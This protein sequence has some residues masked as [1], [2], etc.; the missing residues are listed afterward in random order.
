MTSFV[1]KLSLFLLLSIVL[2]A[3]NGPRA[4]LWHDKNATPSSVAAA[5][6]A[7]VQP[8]KPA[9]VVPVY[10]ATS[11]ARE[12]NLYQ[13]FGTR[14]SSHLNFA[15]VSVGIPA[16]HE[17]GKV[18]TNG[19]KPDPAK[20][21]A[22]V[23]VDMFSGREQFIKSLNDALAEQKGE[24]KEILVFIHGYN[25]NFADSTFRAAQITH[26]YQLNTVTVHYSWPS[27]GAIGLYVYDRDSADVA[28]DGL[29]E[30][31]QIVSETNARQ[32]NVVAH[33][34]GNYVLMEALRTLALTHNRKPIDCISNL[35]MAA[36]DIDVDVFQRQLKDI[37][38]LP[39][40]TAVQVSSKD[41][42]LS[43]SS[44]ITGGHPR[45]GDGSDIALLRG[46]GIVVF[47]MSDVDGGSHGVFA[48]SPTLM[49]L[50]QG[51][52]LARDV[53]EE[54]GQKPGEAFLAD[55]SSVLQ[56]AT[57]L[58]LYTPARIFSSVSD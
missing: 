48:S 14:R 38:Q 26:D 2:S 13:P 18:E 51:G 29:A 11:R 15:E 7:Y 36:P 20:H 8:A 53:L 22:A 42:A 24:R 10:I 4:I 12:N 58:I 56:G 37:G 55:G 19:N 54:Q 17:K 45:V 30:L 28:R 32:I 52:V 50:V 44:R 27:G 41:R 1:S 9:F 46:E 49:A 6:V 34:M 57:S 16:A 40:S 21:F 31:L 39:K 5:K 23:S 47:D 33:S 43:I 3:C 35:L 25:N